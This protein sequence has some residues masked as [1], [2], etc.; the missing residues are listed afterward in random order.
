MVPES[1]QSTSG[2]YFTLFYMYTMKVMYN[3]SDLVENK[4]GPLEIKTIVILF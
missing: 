2:P 4:S 1:C 3:E